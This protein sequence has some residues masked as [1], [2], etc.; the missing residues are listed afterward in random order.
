M[1]AARATRPIMVMRRL[2]TESVIAY[3]NKTLSRLGGCESERERVYVW[4]RN[5]RLLSAAES[6]MARRQHPRSTSSFSSSSTSDRCAVCFVSLLLM[7]LP[8]TNGFCQRHK[9]DWLW[10]LASRVQQWNRRSR[11]SPGTSY[12]AP[13]HPQ[14]NM[15]PMSRVHHPYTLIEKKDMV[16]GKIFIHLHQPIFHFY[17]TVLSLVSQKPILLIVLA[18]QHTAYLASMYMRRIFKVLQ[19]FIDIFCSHPITSKFNAIY[20]A[21]FEV[22]PAWKMY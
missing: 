17:I 13:N 8:K 4:E 21:I 15:A 10:F 14:R 20:F 7:A 16:C 5:F 18:T 9:Q 2:N 6:R 11:R 3:A 19:N 12:R 22:Y 1:G